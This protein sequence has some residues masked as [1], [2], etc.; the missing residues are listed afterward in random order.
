[1][2]FIHGG[3]LVGGDSH[4]GVVEII[5]NFVSKGIIFVSIEYRMSWLGIHFIT[6]KSYNDFRILY[7]VYRRFST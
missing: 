3:G 5:R 7:N 6:D 1:M 4:F 2:I